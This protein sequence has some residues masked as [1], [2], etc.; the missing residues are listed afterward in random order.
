MQGRRCAG[1]SRSTSSPNGARSPAPAP[2]TAHAP[3]PSPQGRRAPERPMSRREACRWASSKRLRLAAYRSRIV[4]L[5]KMPP[6]DTVG[7][8]AAPSRRDRGRQ[9][10]INDRDLG[11]SSSSTSR[12]SRAISAPA[13]V[14]IIG[15]LAPRRRRGRP[16]RGCAGSRSAEAEPL[17]RRR[18]SRPRR[19]PSPR[20]RADGAATPRPA[21]EGG[22]RQEPRSPRLPAHAAANQTDATADSPTA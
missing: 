13:M 14:V 17:P 6:S 12:A 10:A 8:A 3:R 7:V 21:S 22:C 20:G 4:P 18:A 16:D 15:P 1:T 9:H 2:G 5:R 11:R 19:G